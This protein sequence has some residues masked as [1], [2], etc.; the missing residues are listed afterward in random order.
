MTSSANPRP[1]P[2]T[3][4]T[5]WGDA[6]GRWNPQLLRQLRGIISAKSIMLA[7]AASLVIQGLTWLSVVS[8]V[9]N[10][11]WPSFGEAQLNVPAE[12]IYAV[13][14]CLSKGREGSK[15]WSSEEALK[16]CG[17][18]QSE[19][20]RTLIRERP[21]NLL[22]SHYCTGFRTSVTVPASRSG[23]DYRLC[24][25]D[26][27]G[28][29]AINWSRLYRES[30]PFVR[31]L[32]LSLMGLGG[33]YAIA[34]N[35]L[36]EVKLG[37]LEFIRMSP[38]P[39]GRILLGKVLGTPIL[40]L[41]GALAWIPFHLFL[42]FNSGDPAFEWL[43]ADMFG[44]AALSTVFVGALTA[45][46][47]TGELNVMLLVLSLMPMICGAWVLGL[48]AL[49]KGFFTGDLTWFSISLTEA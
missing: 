46:V 30:L 28:A 20:V 23:D 38:E 49:P 21:Y 44:L 36:R 47:W 32:F 10:L 22:R 29:F 37:T 6:L 9:D 7:I 19:A 11:M 33:T 16:T 2:Q 43:A 1:R 18:S 40:F 26:G 14:Q 42:A 12:T 41:V 39:V 35:W 4:V 8:T 15:S 27:K 48:A 45:C 13:D 5:R 31:G 3:R 17:W 24:L 34:Q 25:P